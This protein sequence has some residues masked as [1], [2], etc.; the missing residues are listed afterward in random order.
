MTFLLYLRD[1]GRNVGGPVI[2]GYLEHIPSGVTGAQAEALLG[3]HEQV[4]FLTHGFNVSRD[5]G[6][7]HLE[8]FASYLTKLEDMAL[9]MVLWPGDS[10]AGA[11]G[12]AF[13]GSQADDSGAALYKFVER[14]LPISTTLNFAA[15]SLGTRVML[16][17]INR[18]APSPYRVDQVC[19]MAA[20]VNDFVFADRERYELAAKTCERMGILSSDKD[21]V[22]KYAYPAGNLLEAFLFWKREIGFALGLDGSKNAAVATVANTRIPPARDANHGDYLPD[23]KRGTSPSDNERQQSVE[24]QMSTCRFANALLSGEP[25]P[26]YS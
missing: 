26:T 20:A 15:H 2:S 6:I 11:N 23:F 24:N 3:G 7:Q 10:W 14:V 17:A 19:L 16:E 4:A 13:E 8:A 9:V 25:N 12:Y 1:P 22:L 5:S 18:L 21:T